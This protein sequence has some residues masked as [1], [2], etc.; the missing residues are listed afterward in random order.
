MVSCSES[1]LSFTP[2]QHSQLKYLITFSVQIRAFTLFPSLVAL[3]VLS[4]SYYIKSGDEISLLS[5]LD[6]LYFLPFLFLWRSWRT[7]SLAWSWT[8]SV[9]SRTTSR[10]RTR[11]GKYWQVSS[12]QQVILFF[13]VAW[14]SVLDDC[15]SSVFEAAAGFFFY[16]MYSLFE[17]QSFAT[18]SGKLLLN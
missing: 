1:C 18:L 3:V 17:K 13:S 15:M 10:L 11:G 9:N 2:V 12:W 16:L 14:T 8:S 4:Y 5:F 6:R 7:P